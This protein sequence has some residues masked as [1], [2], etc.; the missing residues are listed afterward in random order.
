MSFNSYFTFQNFEW[1]KVQTAEWDLEII[2][3]NF[4][5]QARI[6]FTD[7]CLNLNDKIFNYYAPKFRLDPPKVYLKA[8]PGEKVSQVV[9]LRN[10]SNGGKQLLRQLELQSVFEKLEAS[11]FQITHDFLPD[12]E[13]ARGKDYHFTISFM[14]K[15]KG[16]FK[17]SIYTLD[18]CRV[19]N[20]FA[21]SAFVSDVNSIEEPLSEYPISPKPA[22]DYIE[23]V[24]PLEKRGLGGVLPPI[25]IIDI[26][27][28]NVLSVETR[29]ALSLQ[30]IDVSSLPPGMYFVRIGEKVGKFVVVR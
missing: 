10:F 14:S 28:N 24:P 19:T 5:A 23:L 25:Q 11:G 6:L 16:F 15:E 9:T 12:E 7:F 29:H 1:G 17:D 20:T 18:S 30:R 21:V 26:F 22:S 13:I 3:P 27:G 8:K 2:D 4:D